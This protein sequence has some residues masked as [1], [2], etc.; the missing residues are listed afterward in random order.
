MV[1]LTG[2]RSALGSH[3]GRADFHAFQS[4]TRDSLPTILPSD[5]TDPDGTK[6]VGRD[7]T[8]AR[9]TR[10]HEDTICQPAR[11]LAPEGF[12]AG[13]IAGLAASVRPVYMQVKTVHCIPWMSMS[14][15]AKARGSPSDS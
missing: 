15:V 10:E 2:R 14:F 5:C 3:T 13:A 1:D 12:D 11:L 9:Q 8:Q 6:K 7:E 4:N